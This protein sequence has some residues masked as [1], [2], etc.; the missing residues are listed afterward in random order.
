MSGASVPDAQVLRAQLAP[1]GD[2]LA[3]RT[4]QLFSLEER[5]RLAGSQQD[6]DDVAA[7]FVARKAIADRVAAV[8]ALVDK[9]RR[10]AAAL[11]TRP[12]V[13]DLGGPVGTS[14]DDAARLLDAILASVEKRIAGAEL[15]Q[16]I[17]AE[18]IA[19]IDADLVLAERLSSE[20]G[21]QVNYVGQL[22][23]Q[24]DQRR[25]LGVLAPLL[26]AARLDLQRADVERQRVLDAFAAVGDRLVH[27]ADEER[28]VR[29]L[30]ERCRAKVQRA[31]VLA[32]PSV[33][34]VGDAPAADGLHGLAWPS[35]RA[36]IEPFVTKVDRL[37]SALAEA[38]RRFQAPLDERDDLR[39]LLQGFRS[40]AGAHGLAEHAQLEP[41][42]R[43]AE[44]LLW[45]APCDLAAAR[46]LVQQ[47]VAAVNER[48]G[49]SA[50]RQPAGAIEDMR[51]AQ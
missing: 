45:A 30:A 38:R 40:K 23:T 32:V 11:V 49:G 33:A 5:C 10:E 47:Y 15:R 13:D 37:A 24:R 14:I 31:P 44:A 3:H 18:Q 1:W 50:G 7:A 51:R 48:T 22:R 35:Q 42:Y 2:W 43:A 17:D 36:R 34:A 26:A 12:L 16:E 6:S 29:A 8:G 4:D 21:A 27:L 20:L 9:N 46:P 25:D 39:G 41:I 19:A 28:E